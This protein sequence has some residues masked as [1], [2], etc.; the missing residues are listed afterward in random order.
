MAMSTYLATLQCL[1]V[2]NSQLNSAPKLLVLVV[3]VEEFELRSCRQLQWQFIGS[4]EQRH[5]LHT[6]ELQSE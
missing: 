5:P 6:A 2:C 4:H 3:A 1:A